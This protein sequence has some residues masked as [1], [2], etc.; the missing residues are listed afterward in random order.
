MNVRL[1]STTVPHVKGL[2]TAEDLLVYCARVSSPQNQHNTETGPRLLKYCIEHG[3]WSV[4]EQ[5]SMTV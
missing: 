4:F 3:H 2:K 5:A 1:I